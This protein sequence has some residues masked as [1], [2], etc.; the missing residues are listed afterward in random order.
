MGN[1]DALCDSCGSSFHWQTGEP[2]V[3][4]ICRTNKMERVE[5][6]ERQ[7]RTSSLWH[8]NGC[9]WPKEMRKSKSVAGNV[10]SQC[11]I[12][13][14]P[15]DLGI[16]CTYAVYECTGCKARLKIDNTYDRLPGESF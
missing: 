14:N 1:I 12:L 11:L 6:Y 13:V 8:E 3:C 15:R 16:W 7:Y 2:R 5:V 10:V 4:N 9:A